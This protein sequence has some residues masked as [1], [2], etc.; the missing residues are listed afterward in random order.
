MMTVRFESSY[1]VDEN[2]RV[3]CGN[4]QHRRFA[5]RH[6]K[7]ASR[8]GLLLASDIKN[9]REHLGRDF[10]IKE[11]WLS[12][13]EEQDIGTNRD[14]RIEIVAS[15][16]SVG[17]GCPQ[18]EKE[19]KQEIKNN[20]KKVQ[21]TKELTALERIRQL[22]QRAAELERVLFVV[23]KEEVKITEIKNPWTNKNV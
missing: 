16:F 14:R 18:H 3:I 11:T 19:L 13:D 7:D 6:K 21:P 23:I 2:T 20:A 4:W 15:V 5:Y 22:E 1:I 12:S 9:A 10:F 17:M 8:I